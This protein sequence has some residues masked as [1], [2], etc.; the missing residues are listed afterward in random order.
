MNAV[1]CIGEQD[2]KKYW[3]KQFCFAYL[4]NMV[5]SY[6]QRQNITTRFLNIFIV[7]IASVF[8][9]KKNNLKQKYGI[10]DAYK[11]K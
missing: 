8:M 3:I 7:S 1:H 5:A 9:L 11:N 6:M 2:Q 4:S 10:Y